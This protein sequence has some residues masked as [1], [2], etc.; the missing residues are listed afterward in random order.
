LQL[1][2]T[3]TKSIEVD[4]SSLVPSLKSPQ[5][6]DM[7][8]FITKCLSGE[9][10][11]ADISGGEEILKIYELTVKVLSGV[12]LNRNDAIIEDIKKKH[13]STKCLQVR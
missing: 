13:S 10:S 3:A 2:V 1:Q 12:C 9:Y 11:N 5:W 7:Y 4:A 8:T 6:L